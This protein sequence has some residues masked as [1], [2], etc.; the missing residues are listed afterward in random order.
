MNEFEHEFREELGEEPESTNDC[1]VST[2]T[3]EQ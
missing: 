3:Q 2:Q 1:E